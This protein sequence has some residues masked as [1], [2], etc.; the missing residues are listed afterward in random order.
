MAAATVGLTSEASQHLEV[1]V[2]VLL[3]VDVCVGGFS[4]YTRMVLVC[5][6]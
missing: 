2:A 4:K 3:L 6:Y 1:G 5:G